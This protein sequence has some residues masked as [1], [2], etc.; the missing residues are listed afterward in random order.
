MNPARSIGPAIVSGQLPHLW[1]YI[2]APVLG[3]A[4]AVPVTNY[5]T[6]KN[7]II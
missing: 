7:Q 1:L 3:A 4:L 2:V 6:I 5:L